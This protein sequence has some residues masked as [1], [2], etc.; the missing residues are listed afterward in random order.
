MTQNT[1]SA[2]F[3][4]SALLLF[5]RQ[6]PASVVGYQFDAVHC[7]TRVTSPDGTAIADAYDPAGN[8]IQKVIGFDTDRNGIPDAIDP[9][10]DGD[11]TPD[12]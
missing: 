8:R 6:V 11:G 10:N 1:I 7:L 5:P 12:P 3:A 2:A 4:M 9:D